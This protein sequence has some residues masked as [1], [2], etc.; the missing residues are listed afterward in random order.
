VKLVKGE[1]VKSVMVLMT[2]TVLAQAIGYLISPILTRIYTAEE[3][4]DLGLYLRIVGFLAALATARYE[5]SLPLPK[6]ESHSYLLYRL[7]IR[8]ASIILLSTLVLASVFSFFMKNSLDGMLFVS[9]TIAGSSFLVFTNLGTS[10]AIRMNHYSQISISRVSQSLTTNSLKWITGLMGMSSIG[11]ITSTL[12]GYIV[13]TFPFI[14]EFKRIKFFYKP[15]RS[16]NKTIALI[17]QH[18]NFP[19]INL[20]HVLIDLGRDLLI[21]TLILTLFEKEIFGYFSHAYS[22]LRIPLVLVGGSIAQVLFKKAADLINANLSLRPLLLKLV[23]YLSTMAIIPFSLLFFFGES[24]FSIVFGE[25]WSISGKYAEIL[26]VWFY[27]NFIASTLSTMPIVLNKQ[28]SFFYWGIAGSILQLG[29]LGGIT[30]YLETNFIDTLIILSATQ[31]A[32]TTLL[33]I[34]LVTYSKDN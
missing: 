26:S 7:S 3:M 27:F 17:R 20:P 1:F 13:S 8:I 11:L 14:K 10:W 2:G 31:T 34:R 28:K 4:A 22:M 16:R 33:I 21:A 5:L 6:N 30:T 12:I 29:V 15:I 32:F 18:K 19:L 23:F 9:L 24:L 25:N